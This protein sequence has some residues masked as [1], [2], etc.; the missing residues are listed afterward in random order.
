MTEK[1][2]ICGEPDCG[3]QGDTYKAVSLHWRGSHAEGEPCQYCGEKKGVR[4]LARHEA[5]CRIDAAL[6]GIPATVEAVR[7]GVVD[8]YQRA[9]DPPHGD[10]LVL[11][12]PRTGDPF[13]IRNSQLARLV[14]DG[15]YMLH[16]KQI[17]P[18]ALN[19]A[20]RKRD[21]RLGRPA[22]LTGV[23]RPPRVESLFEEVTDE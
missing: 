6:G 21:R 17:D 19:E 12:V 3:Y 23:R 18:A 13:T 1:V 8:Y 11:V 22:D 9:V 10:G 14:G 7:S 16:T 15:A 5:H 20:E 4:G 2:F